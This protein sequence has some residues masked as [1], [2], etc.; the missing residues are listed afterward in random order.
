MPELE[1]DQ[2]ALGMHRVDDAAPALDLLLRIDAGCAGIA[3]SARHDRRGFRDDQAMR[4]G[5]LRVIF[6]VQ[7]PRREA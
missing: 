5:A 6:R 1:K 3:A 2:S 7:R 4:R